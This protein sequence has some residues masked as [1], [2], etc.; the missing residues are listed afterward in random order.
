[1]T[2]W[3]TVLP[4]PV[5]ARF[6]REKVPNHP[7]GVKTIKTANNATIRYKEPGKKGVCE[8]TPGV[9]SYTGY[10]DTSPNAHT[11]FWFF[12]ARKDPENAPITLWLNGG[13]G[14]DSLIGLFQELGPCAISDKLESYLN[15]HSWNEVSNVLFLSQPVGVGFSYADKTTGPLLNTTDETFGRWPVINATKIDTT[16]LAAKATWEVLQGFL[17]GLGKLDSK[18]KSKSF[19]LWTESYGGHWGPAFFKYFHEQ[20]KKISRGT[21]GVKLEFN[22]LGI[23]NGVIDQG[24]QANSTPD[25]AVNNTYGIKTVSDEVYKFMKT[26]NEMPLVGCQALVQRCTTSRETNPGV[27]AQSVCAQAATTCKNL[28]Q[29]PY[30]IDSRLTFYDIRTPNAIPDSFVGY[31]NQ[32]SIMD[33]IGVDV[34]YTKDSAEVRSA[35]ELTGDLIFT[36]YLA[37]IEKLLSLPVRVALVYGDADYIAHWFGGEAVSLAVNYTHGQ[38]FAAAGYAP[39]VVNGTEYGVTREYGNFSFTRIYEAGH[40]VPFYQPAASLA[41][42]NRT[43]NGMDLATGKKKIKSNLGSKGPASAT[44]TQQ[45]TRLATS[46]PLPLRSAAAP[47]L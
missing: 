42:F 19:N 41:L 11:F 6:V 20:N 24:L 16:E 40:M 3:R 8:T 37:D 30:Q 7:S 14:S 13:P 22:T 31:L 34:N 23:I 18:I 46:T 1:M 25:F 21:K 39:F 38:Q 45:P 27:I 12:E 35:F 47:R 4:D 10:V 32:A 29:L 15:P 5:S 33:A 9:K 36:D 28:V 2:V 43:L 26:S 44:H 17:G